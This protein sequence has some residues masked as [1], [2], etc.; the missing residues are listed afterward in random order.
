MQNVVTATSSAANSATN[1]SAVLLDFQMFCDNIRRHY[2]FPQQ[3]NALVAN[4]LLYHTD[5]EMLKHLEEAGRIKS[6]FN[7]AVSLIKI[8]HQSLDQ[9]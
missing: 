3:C 7:C 9:V 2:P 1:S 6:N 4:V 8:G 5:Q